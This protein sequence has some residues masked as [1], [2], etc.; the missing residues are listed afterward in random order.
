MIAGGS[1]ITPMI[2]MLRYIDE[3]C[4]PSD[5]TLIYCVRTEQ[6]FFSRTDW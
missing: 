1:G 3:L 4:I 6:D 2:A 5:A